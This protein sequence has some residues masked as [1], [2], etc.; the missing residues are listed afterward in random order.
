MN[1]M[2][3]VEIRSVESIADL[4][5]VVGLFAEVWGL[6]RGDELVTVSLLRAMTHA[7]HYVAA[8][9]ED[10][11]VRGACFGFFSAPAER[12][13]HSHISGV[14]PSAR[15]RGIGTALKLHQRQW[16]LDR[17]LESITWTFDPLVARNAHL[18]IGVLGAL[19]EE[20][21][22]DFYGELP[23]DIN[24]GEDTDRILVRWQLTGARAVR[25]AAESGAA[26]ALIAEGDAP[27]AMPVEESASIVRIQLP[28][29][30]EQLRRE[31]PDLAARW[32]SAV[33]DALRDYRERG[34]TVVG[35][36][37]ERRYLLERS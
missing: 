36:D 14:S 30:I 4:H 9:F 25:T 17:G 8:A 7:G 21:L 16:A 10:G 35:F 31:A 12:A 1:T 24:T 19:P 5:Q 23:D 33:R 11:R 3:G 20:Y 37:D 2:T 27:R 26:D 13:L 28:A 29:D 15:G 18:N 34:W 32:R 22:T 6:E